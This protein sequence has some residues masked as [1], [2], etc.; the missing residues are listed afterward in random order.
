MRIG[1]TAYRDI[2]FGSSSQ[3]T[4]TGLAGQSLTFTDDSGAVARI[5]PTTIVTPATGTGTETGTGGGGGGA[6]PGVPT[7]LIGALT[8]ASYPIRGSSGVAIVSITSTTNVNIQV[9]GDRGSFDVASIFAAGDGT[10]VTYLPQRRIVGFAAGTG[11]IGSETGTTTGGG[12]AAGA[13]TSVFRSPAVQ[14]SSTFS[15]RLPINVLDIRSSI[16]TSAGL[17]DI[18]SITNNSPGEIV[19]V[20]AKTIGYLT[21]Q[22]IGYSETSTPAELLLNTNFPS[23]STSYPMT[24]TSF[25]IYTAGPIISLQSREAIGTVMA[26]ATSGGQLI[27]GAR[28]GL[29]VANSDGID[30]RGVYEGI[31]GNLF[32]QGFNRIEIGEGVAAQG[33]G[34]VSEAGI[35]AALPPGVTSASAGQPGEIRLIVGRNADIRG[36]IFASDQIDSIQLTNGSLINAFVLVTRNVQQAKFLQGGL[37][38]TDTPTEVNLNTTPVIPGSTPVVL[39]VHYNI[40]SINI[41]NG[42]ILGTRIAVGDWN[43][44]RVGSGFGIV[45]SSITSVAQFNANGSIITDGLGIRGS[46]ISAGASLNFV[47]VQG[48]GKTL[49]IRTWGRSLLQSERRNRYDAFNGRSLGASNDL[50]RVFGTS[51]TNSKIK[52]VTDSGILED[53]TILGSKDL[54]T[55]QAYAIRS[56][57]QETSTQSASFPM[58]IAFASSTGR[59]KTT[60]SV[61]G[62]FMSTGKINQFSV[63]TNLERA[64]LQFAGRVSEIAVGRNVRGTVGINV[65]GP[66]G[67]L[68]RLRVRRGLFGTV[69][70]NRDIGRIEARS[71]GAVIRATQNIRN[72][73]I[74]GD[75]VT[76][77]KISAK[78]RINNAVIGGDI[79]TGASLEAWRIE[80]LTVGGTI[81]G[82][83]KGYTGNA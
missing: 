68:D 34:Q 47:D 30:R 28:I 29:V 59:I 27:H 8:V 22:K 35:F 55:V 53:S 57:D 45:N 76:G 64:N 61:D 82:T 15:G 33:T 63:G 79:Q 39:P 50:H 78:S 12:G 21:G 66:E 43:S 69:L 32:S 10:E 51:R 58:R 23:T 41:N 73:N 48:D 60:A 11:L 74:L 54:G 1:G 7:S 20:R 72:I 18:T 80:K 19:G 70:V 77:A 81:N 24:S 38:L 31:K 42:G 37:V 9:T 13:T 52:G 3:T 16:G 67:F 4:F 56:T 5:T 44:I 40:G 6:T 65:V 83:V 25:G 75:V 14:N 2:F 49:D 17:Q 62:L 46:A 36:M 71:I 26:T